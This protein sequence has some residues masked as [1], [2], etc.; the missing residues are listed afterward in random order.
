MTNIPEHANKLVQI[1][2]RGRGERLKGILKAVGKEWLSLDYNPVDFVLDGIIL[3][4]RKYLIKV[5]RTKNEAF[6]EEVLKAK[7]TQG[8]YKE[9]SF[10]LNNTVDLFTG[11][12]NNKAI[13][14]EL[15]DES[16]V[17]IG[18]ITKINNKSFRMRRLTPTGNWLDETSYNYSSIRIIQVGG[19][20]VESLLAYIDSKN[21][22]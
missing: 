13:Q 15:G 10:N 16:I 6:I 19:D 3:I 11:L 8:Y 7:D 12:E 2:L 21:N 1:K 14:I 5:E 18:K 22:K 17:Y 9:S 20:Y 4:N